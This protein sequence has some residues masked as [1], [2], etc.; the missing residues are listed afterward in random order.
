[1]DIS[2]IL[3]RRVAVYAVGGWY[4]WRNMD[5]SLQVRRDCQTFWGLTRAEEDQDKRKV[6]VP[7]HHLIIHLIIH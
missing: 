7:R 1:M 6:R 2:S 4:M 5:A 3:T